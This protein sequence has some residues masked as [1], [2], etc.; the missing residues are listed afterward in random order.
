[1]N[2]KKQKIITHVGMWLAAIAGSI[3]GLGYAIAGY[4]FDWGPGG[5]MEGPLWRVLLVGIPSALIGIYIGELVVRILAKKMF[6]IRWTNI[7]NTIRAFVIVFLGCILAFIVGLEVGFILGKI[8]GAIEGLEWLEV[9]LYAPIMAILYGI[10]PS[11]AAGI[12]FSGFVFVFL[13]SGDKQSGNE[14]TK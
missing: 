6:A 3:S 13:K 12:L 5:S 11:M 2:E 7:R 14:I 1:M 10:M 4:L 8:T 9:L